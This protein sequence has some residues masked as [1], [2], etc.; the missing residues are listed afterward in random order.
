M[1]GPEQSGL[2]N[3]DF[4]TENPANNNVDWP[5]TLVFYNGAGVNNV[6]DQLSNYFG[7]FS[8]DSKHIPVTY[9]GGT[10]PLGQRRR[11]EG[12]CVPRTGSL[13]RRHRVG[14]NEPYH[15]P[16]VQPAR[17]PSTRRRHQRRTRQAKEPQPRTRF[18]SSPG[19]RT[20]GPH[21]PTSIPA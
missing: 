18:D 9:L 7:Q 13:E 20:Q 14:N 6:K 5:I 15:P 16:T 19:Q 12:L 21:Q 8:T 3:Y 17:R 2:V 4:E 11:Q 1:H 10:Q